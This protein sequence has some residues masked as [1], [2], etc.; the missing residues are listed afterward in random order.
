[1]RRNDLQS[2]WA[3]YGKQF[4]T[5]GHLY[6]MPEEQP[7]LYPELLFF[8]LFTCRILVDKKLSLSAA[9]DIQ[10]HLLLGRGLEPSLRWEEGRAYTL[11]AKV[12]DYRGYAKSAMSATLMLREKIHFRFGHMGFGLFSNGRRFGFCA[13]ASVFALMT[14]I[15]KQHDGQG[16]SLDFLWVCAGK[17]GSA[18]LGGGLTR[19]NYRQAAVQ[20]YKEV[21]GDFYPEY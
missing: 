1:M 8:C 10:K 7:S 6:M 11:P 20:I 18:D 19:G 9:R 2:E 13:A 12:V 3:F 14:T 4:D 15:Y 5:V 16:Q 21:T 17:L